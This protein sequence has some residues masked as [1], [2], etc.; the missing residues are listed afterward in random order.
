MKYEPMHKIYY[1]QPVEGLRIL[2]NRRNSEG[3]IS[4]PIPI[5][6]YNR[7]NTYSAFFM[8]HPILVT[9]LLSLE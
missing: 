4:L 7:R 9:L 8:Y 3:S 2:D 5:H 6:E 1:K